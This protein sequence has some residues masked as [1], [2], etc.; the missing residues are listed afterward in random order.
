FE[1]AK[2]PQFGGMGVEVEGAGDQDVEA[3]ID[4]LARSRDNVLPADGAVLGT[5]Q[6]RGAA[7]GTVLAFDESPAGADEITRPRRQALEGDAVALVLL[8][9]AFGLEIVDHDGRK[10]LPGKVRIRGG[11]FTLG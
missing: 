1:A 6:D 5:N 2:T 3:R 10:V 9:D 7:L 4:G 8:L 11:A